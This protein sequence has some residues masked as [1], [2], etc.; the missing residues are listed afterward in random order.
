MAMNQST[1]AALTI[2]AGSL[3]AAAA[4]SSAA[5]T[6]DVT[7]N[8]QAIM[9]TVNVLTTA[10]AASGNKQV[11]VYG[12]E[13]EDGTNYSGASSTADNVDGTDKTLTAIGS[14]T[15]LTLLGTIQ[16]NAGAVAVTE[17]GVFE[18]VGRFGCVPRKWGIVLFNDA[19][20]ALGA[21]VTATYTEISYS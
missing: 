7:K 9:L 8:V 6:P 20:T 2:T 15:N 16:L 12:Y 19:G 21:T 13:S 14:P 11:V 10:T 1:S 4:R 5:V 3:A 18:V 17:R